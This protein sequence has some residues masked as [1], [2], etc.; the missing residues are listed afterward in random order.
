M[1]FNQLAHKAL[2]HFNKNS[3]TILTVAAVCGVGA[4][5]YLTARGTIKAAEAI[6]GFESEHGIPTEPRER[7]KQ[8]VQVAWRCYVPAAT[9]AAATVACVVGVHRVGVGRAIAA[10]ASLV[11]AERSFSEYRNKVVEEYGQ[12]KDDSI[13]SDIA[14][15]RV[16]A[17]EPPSQQVLLTGPGNILSLELYTGRY[18]ASDMETLRRAQNT[19]NEML[20]RHDYATLDDFYHIIGLRPT[21]TSSQLGWKSTKLMDL[22]FT[23]ALSTDGRPC[24][25]FEYNYV[26]PIYELEHE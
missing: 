4:T 6:H 20:I 9:T 24:I 2:F 15:D 1:N 5:A 11:I 10:Q 22:H 14:K 13:R 3:P 26:K 7:A 18:F 21:T 16:A 8:H 25:A 12:R 17:I 19:L 23:S